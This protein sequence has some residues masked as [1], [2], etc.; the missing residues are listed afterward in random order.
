MLDL[1]QACVRPV[2]GL[3]QGC[4]RAVPGLCQI[5]EYPFRVALFRAKRAQRQGNAGSKRTQASPSPRIIAPSAAHVLRPPLPWIIHRVPP[6]SVYSV[7]Q[8]DYSAVFAPDGVVLARRPDYY[9]AVGANLWFFDDKFDVT[10]I[11]RLLTQL[12]K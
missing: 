10:D 6:S 12:G 5:G 8:K 1:C 9:D 2:S 4:V 3:C 11:Q 7:L